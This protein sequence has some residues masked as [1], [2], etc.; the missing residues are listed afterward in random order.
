VI[1]SLTKYQVTG[2]YSRVG[3]NRNDGIV[4]FLHR[5]SPEKSA[6]ILWNNPSLDPAALPKIRSSSD[7]VFGMWNRVAAPN[8]NKIEKFISMNVI[9]EDA[10]EIINRAL[11]TV[12]VDDVQPWPGTDFD[13]MDDAGK[14]LLGE[15]F[16]PLLQNSIASFYALL[17][18][19]RFTSWLGRGVLPSPAPKATRRQ[20]H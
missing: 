20:V 18:H 7:L 8:G 6:E 11:E 5:L 15:S 16:D 2:A 12:H 10:E 9:N 19:S 1:C 17:I 3:I 4:Y 13:M 14:A